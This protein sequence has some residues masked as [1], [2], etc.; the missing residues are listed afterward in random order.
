MGFL[1]EIN[2]ESG[3]PGKEADEG[4]VTTGTA[5]GTEPIEPPPLAEPLGSD[6]LDAPAPGPYSAGASEVESA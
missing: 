5:G 1:D 4:H 2:H 3:R 6:P